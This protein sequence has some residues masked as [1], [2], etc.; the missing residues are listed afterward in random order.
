MRDARA[1][2]DQSGLRREVTAGGNLRT[3]SPG[4]TMGGKMPRNGIRGSVAEEDAE[5][6]TKNEGGRLALSKVEVM[7]DEFLARLYREGECQRVL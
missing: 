5:F 3:L 7:K 4:R 6:L 2:S 1:H